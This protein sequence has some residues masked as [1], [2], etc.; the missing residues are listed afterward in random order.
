MSTFQK[1]T[2]LKSMSIFCLLN[3]KLKNINT[4]EYYFIVYD[5]N[6]TINGKGFTFL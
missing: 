4:I 5:E 3:F 1:W 6:N 2:W